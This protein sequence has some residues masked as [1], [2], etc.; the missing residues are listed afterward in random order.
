MKKKFF[1]FLALFLM[2]SLP[3]CNRTV[4]PDT[5]DGYYL[6]TAVIFGL[7]D[8]MIWLRIFTTSAEEFDVYSQA[9]YNE[10]SR[11]HELF[12]I[13]NE[14]EGITNL[15][16]INQNAGVS[17]VQV[18]QSIISL[19]QFG[20]EAYTLSN[21]TV[22]IAMGSVLHLWHEFRRGARQGASPPSMEALESAARLMDINNIVIDEEARTIFLK[23][24]GMSLDVG[25]LAKGYA[26]E[27]VISI[28]KDLGMH[29]GSITI[30]GDIRI[31]G[32]PMNG[33][34]LWLV[35]VENPH[36]PQD[37]IIDVIEISDAAVVTTG[38]YMRYA[39][40]NGTRYNHIIDPFTLMPAIRYSSATV[41]HS[42]ARLAEILSTAIFILPIN[43]G[44][45]LLESQGGKGLWVLPDGS[46]YTTESY[47]DLRR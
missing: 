28:A 18:D 29:S 45:A 5:G 11:L 17:P 33:Q 12:D 14:Y 47:R 21:G 26:L 38:D 35:Y 6:H 46:I 23:E 42:D 41:V 40:Y 3:G 31:V 34:G 1:Q 37:N 2:L 19:V 4:V 27:S 36:A 13:Y 25:A 44:I 16:T 30:G 22:N 32:Q 24:V 15:R 43:E 20:K 10:L 7:F 8:T 9:I 39:I